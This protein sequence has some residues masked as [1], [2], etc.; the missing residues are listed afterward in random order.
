[1]TLKRGLDLGG[2]DV[3]VGRTQHDIAI[4]DSKCA[5]IPA[6]APTKDYLDDSSNYSDF[7]IRKH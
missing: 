4:F 7:I 6:D 1:M 2:S 5:E 3:R